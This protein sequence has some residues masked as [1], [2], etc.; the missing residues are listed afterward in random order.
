[1]EGAVTTVG[2]RRVAVGNA[3]LLEREH[4][5]LDGLAERARQLAGQ[6]RTTVQVGLDGH[7][8]GVIAIADAPRPTSEDAVAAL[9]QRGVRAAMLT[10]DSRATAERVAAQ[11]GIG[12]VIAEVLPANKAAKIAELQGQ[13]RKVAMVGDG[14]NDAPALARADV[15]IAIG[16]G[17]DVA[18]ETAD[19]VLMHSDP[20]DIA[21]AITISRGTR[22]KERQNLAWATGYNSLAIPIAAGALTSAGFTLS[23][24][25]AALS[26]SGSSIIVA[27]NAIWLRR[28]PLPG[29]PASLPPAA[30]HSRPNRRAPRP[31]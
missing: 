10:G 31:G 2:G 29:R 18:V 9:L 24:E 13:N 15:G 4:I 5:S 3:R 28:L 19:V 8:A 20:L 30:G 17:T 1:G 21:T 12:E 6:G 11:I 26:M 14:V 27:L 22:R 7:A 25:I 16:T 23:P